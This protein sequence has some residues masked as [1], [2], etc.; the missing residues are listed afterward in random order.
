MRPIFLMSSIEQ[1]PTTKEEKI[2]GTI[3]ILIKLIKSEPMGLM[4]S[5]FGQDGARPRHPESLR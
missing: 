4:Y 1:M 3:S 2:S 5:A